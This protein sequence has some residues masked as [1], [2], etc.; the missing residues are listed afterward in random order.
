MK[1]LTRVVLASLVLV[2]SM[3]TAEES[4]LENYRVG[5]MFGGGLMGFVDSDTRDYATEGG[6]WEARLAFNNAGVVAI[7]AAYIGSLQNIDALGL[8]SDATLLGSGAEA[9]VRVN[10]WRGIVQPYVLIGGGWTRYDIRSSSS[11]T[12]DIDDVENVITMP[13]GAGV[14]YRYQ[15]VLFDLRGTYRAATREDLI[16]LGGAASASLDTWSATLKAGFEF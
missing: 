1:M 12:S 13:M 14:G 10:V 16:D 15:Q 8:D 5:A 7:E 3:A 2:P 9:N 4:V 6:A 11:N